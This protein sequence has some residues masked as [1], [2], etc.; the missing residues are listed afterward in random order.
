[1]TADEVKA[2]LARAARRAWPNAARASDL[3]F[4]GYWRREAEWLTFHAPHVGNGLM[5]RF[6][7]D[8][9]AAAREA[10][11][12]GEKPMPHVVPEVVR[13]I[14]EQVERGEGAPADAR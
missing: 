8:S 5:E 6:I 12:C 1:M 7:A 10:E 13:R 14:W 11:R 2:A 4:P 3:P 9:V